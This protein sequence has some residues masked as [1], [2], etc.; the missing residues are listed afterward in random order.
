MAS[1]LAIAGRVLFG[2]LAL[3]LLFT[4]TGYFSD[5]TVFIKAD[6]SF[7]ALTAN[8]MSLAG[9]C[10]ACLGPCKIGLLKYT[11][12]NGN[13]L[14]IAPTF[15][16]FSA[17]AQTESLYDFCPLSKEALAFAE[18]LDMN[19][20]VCQSSRS[21]WGSTY[22]AVTGTPQQRMDIIT[23]L[24]LSVA[25][26]MVCELQAAIDKSNECVSTWNM[27]AIGRLFLYPTKLGEYKLRQN[28]VSPSQ[29]LGSGLAGV[30]YRYIVWDFRPPA[31]IDTGILLE[32]VYVPIFHWLPTVIG[33][34][35]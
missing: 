10:T 17:M 20:A 32:P 22:S 9:G 23:T 11:M 3:L 15:N 26:Q 4:F 8:D 30:G 27:I 12:F 25:P 13:A 24:N 19:G 7:F 35:T 1:C 5:G 6:S 28:Y 16:A 29:Q 18:A 14:T 2:P 21:D 34:S 33:H 31:L